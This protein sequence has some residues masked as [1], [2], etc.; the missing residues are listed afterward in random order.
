MKRVQTTPAGLADELNRL[1]QQFPKAIEQG[2]V[3]GATLLQGALVQREI[4]SSDPQPVDQG[5]YKA[6]WVLQEVEGGAVVGNTSK[7]A[8]WV[9]RGRAPG[10]TPFGPILEWV[11]RKGFVR[12][13]VK[14][15]KK[16]APGPRQRDS[17]G[18]Y[19]GASENEIEAAEKTAAL[20]IQ[21]KIE[22]QGVEPRWVL[23]RAMVALQSKMA[24]ILRR[25]VREVSA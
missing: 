16:A 3:E 1:G 20:A 21:R 23:R 9:E 14:A 24:G 15:A 18:R 8:L 17:K 4:A 7:Q 6:A 19:Q 12:S 22:Q 5:Q 25:A 2:M 10:P 13:A 11:R